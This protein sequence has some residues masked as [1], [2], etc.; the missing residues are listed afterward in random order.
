MTNFINPGA[1][2]NGLV[3][4]RCPFNNGPEYDIQVSLLEFLSFRHRWE[5]EFGS[6]PWWTDMAWEEKVEEYVLYDF[7]KHKT[8]GMTFSQMKESYDR[9]EESGCWC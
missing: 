9:Y 1:Q 7:Y 2:F 3:I 4:V 5:C 6:R 8:E